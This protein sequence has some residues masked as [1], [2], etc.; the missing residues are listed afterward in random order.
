M[1][2]SLIQAASAH[3]VRYAAVLAL[4]L[5]LVAGAVWGYQFYM[6]QQTPAAA[7]TTASAAARTAA[8]TISVKTLEE[9]YGIRLR[10]LAV[11]AL[12]GMIDLRYMIVDKAKAAALADALGQI[13]L[14]AGDDGTTL[15]MASG[16][17]MHRDDRIDNGQLNFHFF[18]NAHNAIKP[19]RPVTVVI[20]PVRLEAIN[21][22]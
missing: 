18:A 21:A 22:Q 5:A 7:N 16:H 17:G 19:G 4:L 2:H 15:T 8:T 9:R 20:G 10:L 3:R 13:K 14:I 12:G 1:N 6:A 11:T